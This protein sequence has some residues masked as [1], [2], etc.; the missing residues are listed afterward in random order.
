MKS[1][2]FTLFALTLALFLF[3]NCKKEHNKN[4][5]AFFYTDKG[6]A[7]QKLSLFIDGQYK[8]DLPYLTV[9]PTC[10]N[11]DPMRQQA[12]PLTLESGKYK[13]DAR[14]KDG[15]VVSSSTIK[16]E[17]RK[18]STKGTKGGDEL[19]NSGDMITIGLFPN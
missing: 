7:E 15:N 6:S 9:H 11:N 18:I 14:D 17:C 19:R 12:L 5:K 13:L 16:M 2:I 1:N 3:S 4:Y 8:G 10:D